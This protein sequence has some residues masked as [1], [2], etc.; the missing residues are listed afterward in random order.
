VAVIPEFGDPDALVKLVVL[1][2]LRLN[3]HVPGCTHPVWGQM[4]G[5]LNKLGYLPPEVRLDWDGSDPSWP[6]LRHQAL[7]LLSSRPSEGL[8]AIWRQALPC[9]DSDEVDAALRTLPCLLSL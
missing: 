2:Q 7:V 6:D 3:R 8:L 9:W 1:T 4:A 5:Q